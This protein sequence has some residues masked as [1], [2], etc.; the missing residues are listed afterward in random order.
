MI[1]PLFPYEY[2]LTKEQSLKA[3]NAIEL[4][5]PDCPEGSLMFA[6]VRQAIMDLPRKCLGA[7]EFIE[8]EMWCC[9]VCGVESE[10]VRRVVKEC[11][12]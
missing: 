8:G 1:K 12:K 11:R 10:W 7:V 9:E 2:L 3:S 5:F 6:V 4:Q